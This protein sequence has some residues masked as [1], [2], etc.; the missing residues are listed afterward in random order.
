MGRQLTC[1]GISQEL[2][3]RILVLI[4]KLDYSNDSLIPSPI[5][6]RPFSPETACLHSSL[7]ANCSKA[8]YRGAPSA[9]NQL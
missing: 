1:G 3:R 2:S 7:V 4:Y 8:K 9:D 6:G 5:D